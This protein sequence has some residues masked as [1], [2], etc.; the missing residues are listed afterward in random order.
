M[1]VA[2]G[3]KMYYSKVK[4]LAA[5]LALCAGLSFA[6]QSSATSENLTSAQIENFQKT[7]ILEFQMK[8]LLVL[9]ALSAELEFLCA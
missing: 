5:L 3:G 8:M 1:S 4:I 6:Q 7:L 9:L 2:L